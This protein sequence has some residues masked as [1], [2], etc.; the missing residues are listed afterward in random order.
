MPLPHQQFYPLLFC[1]ITVNVNVVEEADSMLV[2]LNMN[3]KVYLD[4]IMLSF[5][6]IIGI[7]DSLS[8]IFYFLDV[9]LLK[10]GSSF[11]KEEEE[12]DQANSI[13]NLP[14]VTSQRSFYDGPMPTPRQKPFQSGSTPM[15]LTHRFMVSL[16]STFNFK[17]ILFNSLNC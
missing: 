10:A 5:F 7:Y 14:L 1:T 8:M 16:G 11:S 9:T 6:Y 4:F 15:H 3:R 13:H 12:D 2:L 17:I